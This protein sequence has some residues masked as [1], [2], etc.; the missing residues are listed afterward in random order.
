MTYVLII[1]AYAFN[2]NPYRAY[3][4]G[5]ASISGYATKG[6]CLAAADELR[7]NDSQIRGICV[8]GPRQ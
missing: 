6:D 4:V 8:R 2:D 5:A 7:N 1:L 3:G